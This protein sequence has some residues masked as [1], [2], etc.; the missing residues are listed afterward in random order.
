M[1][2]R[3]FTE[4]P[5]SVGESYV[6]HFGVAARFV[7]VRGALAVSCQTKRRNSRSGR[8]KGGSTDALGAFRAP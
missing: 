7:T 3:L 4:H 2:R 6:Q 1:F 5:E 8:E